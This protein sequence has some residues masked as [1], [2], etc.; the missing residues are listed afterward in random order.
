VRAVDR[1]DAIDAIA[2]CS[3]SGWRGSCSRA[4][5]R[6]AT[7]PGCAGSDSTQCESLTASTTPLTS[8]PVG[9]GA[10]FFFGAPPAVTAQ[11][12]AR[13]S[14]VRVKVE[15]D[16]RHLVADAQPASSSSCVLVVV[17]DRR[18]SSR[19]CAAATVPVTPSG[20]CS[21]SEPSAP[22]ASTDALTDGT[23]AHAAGGA[24]RVEQRGE[25]GAGRRAHSDGRS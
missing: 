8:L 25:V 17:G 9:G 3:V 2:G 24:A 13:R 21:L 7:A 20:S 23:A 18:R 4:P 16:A 1:R 14:R 6:T 12:R 5:S 11:R 15:H 10:F 19:T 22:R